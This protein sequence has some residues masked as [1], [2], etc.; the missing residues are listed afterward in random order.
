MINYFKAS[1]K[2][3]MARRFTKEYPP[4]IATYQL[5]D[6]GTVEFANWTNPLAPLQQLS[7]E[8]VEF[9]KKFIKKGDLVIDIGANIGDTTVPMA[10]CAGTEG[11]ALGFDPN[12]YVFKILQANASLNKDKTNIVPVPFAIS[13]QEEEFYFIS[14]EAS[15][16]NGGIS[17]TK[18]SKHGKFVHSEK[19]KGVNLKNF[20]ETHYRQ[21]LNKLSFI[22]IDT[23]GYDKEIIRSISDLI[24]TY[25]P[26]LIAESFGKATDEAKM[27]LFGNIERLG[28][29]IFYFEDFNVTAKIQKLHHKSDM[30]NYR[31]TINIYALPEK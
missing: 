29:E 22:K 6:I 3:K 21:W 31:Q 1:F 8:M 25:K 20:L 18:N 13:S 10:L 11:L 24:V 26:A 23:E 17:P 9:F 30:T 19:I 15:F 5:N 2:R 28:Y 14:S 12:P 16:S 7:P 27:E 4:K